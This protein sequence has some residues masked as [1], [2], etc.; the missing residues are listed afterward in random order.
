MRGAARH[1]RAERDAECDREGRRTVSDQGIS[2]HDSRSREKA[3]F[4]RHLK[5]T[6]RQR[7]TVITASKIAGAVS[8]LVHSGFCVPSRSSRRISCNC[9]RASESSH[10]F[11]A[12]S[13]GFQGF[14]LGADQCA[15]TIEQLGHIS[16]ARRS[17]A[18]PAGPRIPE[19]PSTGR[20]RSSWRAPCRG[21]CAGRRIAGSSSQ[22]SSSAP[23]YS[24]S[25]AG[26]TV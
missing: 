1:E 26:E 10:E 16:V 21:K 2:R 12:S 23:M 11:P 20:R 4:L 15:Q 8:G 19:R 7:T 13:S 25:W 22:A 6:K 3:P 18:D 24:A 9:L 5:F 17:V 14:L